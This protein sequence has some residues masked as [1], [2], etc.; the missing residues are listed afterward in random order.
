LASSSFVPDANRSRLRVLVVA[1]YFPPTVGGGVQRVLSFARHLPSF[2]ID[3]EVLTPLDAGWLAP[4]ASTLAAIP[5]GIAVHRVRFRGPAKRVLPAARIAAAPSGWRRA[6]TRLRL[7]PQRLLVP[8]SEITWLVDAYP[9]ARR[10]LGQRRFDAVLTSVPPHSMSVLGALLRRRGL[11]WVADWRDPWLEHPDLRRDHGAVRAKLAVTALIA[12]R[13]TR[14]MDAI[15]A[16]EGAADEAAR[17]APHAQL[18]VVPNGIEPAEF[19][20]PAPS[21][22]ADRLEFLFCGYFFGD[23]SPGVFL[24]G[25]A[26]LLDDRPQLRGVVSARFVGGFPA[27]DRRLVD[28]LD[29]SEV[30]RIDQSVPHA[31]AVRLQRTAGC[32]LLFMQEAGG[33]GDQFVPQKTHEQIAAGR[34]VL[35]LIAPDGAAAL[36]LR[37]HARVFVAGPDDVPAVTAAVR[38]VV[39]AF[40]DEQPLR[41]RSVPSSVLAGWSRT[42]RAEQVAELIRDAVAR[43][44]GG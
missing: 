23:R 35:A 44:R 19:A 13:V 7:A 31:E 30:V 28:D 36:L 11:A 8:D 10:L 43:R 9:A 32:N 18:I 4:D 27:R 17:A 6:L 29:L 21:V 14:R 33:R 12:R 3:V 22:A 5:D 40:L 41:G 24:R 38:D 20:D 15:S 34:P 39:D 37:Q 2:G 26:A 25:L 42:A 16:T 1:F